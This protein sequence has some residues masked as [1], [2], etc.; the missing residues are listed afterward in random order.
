MRRDF[1]NL[2]QTRVG[3]DARGLHAGLFEVGQILAVEL[4]AVAVTLADEL[5]AI[6]LVGPRALGQTAFV[7]AQT[8]GA[9]LVGDGLLVFHDVDDRIG[10]GVIHLERI[11]AVEVEH[12]AREL[13]HRH[14]HAETY[15]EERDVVLAGMAHGIHLAVDAAM[16]EAGRHD[17]AVEAGEL[18]GHVLGQDV[19]GMYQA[20]VELAVVIGG[21]VDERLGDGLISVGQ[22][23]I[24]AHKANLDSAGG[25]A[26]LV[27]KEDP[28]LHVGLA[29][30]G[31][32]ELAHGY[33]VEPLLLHLDG[34]LVDAADVD[35]LDDGV[36]VHIAEEGHLAAQLDAQV[37]LRAQHEHVGLDAVFEQSLDGVLR[38]LGLELARGAQIGHERQVDEHGLVAE[39]P[40]KLADGLDVGQRFDVAHG[41]AYFG[42]HH[43]IFVVSAHQH[44]VALDFVGD[45]R[46]YLDGLAQIVALTLLV[47]DVLVDAPGGHVIVLRGRDVE[48]ALVVTE[49]EVGFGAVVGDVAFAV[50]I[51]VERPRVDVEI[52]V[53]LLDGHAETA[54][55]K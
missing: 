6:G 17:D 43:V 8:H 18:V 50:L 30:G 34:H 7:A 52:R 54:C 3:V 28:V 46:N 29:L 5:G 35:R 22:L 38:G 27:E 26:H 4:V 36:G 41:A 1:D 40:L 16:T 13:D 49:V 44:Y 23:D 31:Q 12:V 39:L 14:L 37:V 10:R 19:F 48:E 33:L 11:G 32:L 2:D 9:A 25:V 47:D 55:L 15:S 20:Q 42:N 51:G 24:L 53:E 45:V 21:G